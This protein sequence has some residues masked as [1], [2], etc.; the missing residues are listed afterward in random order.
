MILWGG[1]CEMHEVLIDLVNSWSTAPDRVW[2]VLEMVR[3]L[4]SI[5]VAAPGM[6]AMPSEGRPGR[7]TCSRAVL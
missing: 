6:S 5:P 4:S 3:V 1:D 2:Q 7:S